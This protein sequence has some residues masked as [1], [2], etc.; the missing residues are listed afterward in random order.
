MIK[1][2]I[3]QIRLN[4][5]LTQEKF[6]EQLGL[7]RNSVANYE[8]GRNTPLDAIINS[9]CREFNINEEWLKTGSGEMYCFSDSDDEFTAA[10]E[11]IGVK[12]SIAREII[13]NYWHLNT[14]EKE[15]FWNIVNKI[16]KNTEG[17]II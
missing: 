5:G 16:L 2:R 7:K 11:N 12:D 17:E 14:S 1:D 15:L 6:A 8:I 13:L 10:M 3:K 9:I 4:A